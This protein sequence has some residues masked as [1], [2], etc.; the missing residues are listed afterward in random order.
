MMGET[1]QTF[2]GGRRDDGSECEN[3]YWVPKKPGLVEHWYCNVA[4][5]DGDCLRG[6]YR[7]RYGL[8][9]G[10]RHCAVCGTLLGVTDKGEPTRQARE[11]ADDRP[12][13]ERVRQAQTPTTGLNA[14]IGQWPGDETDEEITEGLAMIEGKEENNG[15]TD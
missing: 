3:C 5:E 14:I 11:P 1:E 9:S 7:I 15:R 12:L 4:C 13:P 2:C 8:D 10:E 6:H